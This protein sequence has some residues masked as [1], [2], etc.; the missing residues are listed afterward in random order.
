MPNFLNKR[1]PGSTP[2]M[3]VNEPYI[4]ETPKPDIQD[5][6]SI[7]TPKK[8]PLQK[9]FSKKEPLQKESF[10]GGNDRALEQI[11]DSI[12]QLAQKVHDISR[13][14]DQLMSTQ[15][16]LANAMQ[17]TQN[18]LRYISTTVQTAS[19]HTNSINAKVNDLQITLDKTEDNTQRI[20]QTVDNIPQEFQRISSQ[21]A[22]IRV[23]TSVSNNDWQNNW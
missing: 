16:Q 7:N 3:Q 13:T 4:I 23:Y 11:Q 22:N 6:R 8:E 9:E 19:Q 5:N 18:D 15:N 20:K 1:I 2:I 14:V 12:R 17:Q 21:I 10:F